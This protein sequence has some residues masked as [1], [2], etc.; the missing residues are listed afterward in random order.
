[1]DATGTSRSSDTLAGSDTIEITGK[2]M[3]VAVIFRFM[4]VVIVLNSNVSSIC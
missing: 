3:V 4:V 2:I 1:M